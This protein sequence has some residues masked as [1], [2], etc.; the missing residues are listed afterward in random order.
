[1]Y[2]YMCIYIYI[3]M[4]LYLCKIPISSYFSRCFFLCFLR[5]FCTF[6]DRNK[7]EKLRNNPRNMAKFGGIR[8]GGGG[9]ENEM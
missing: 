9:E 7:V 8:G 3:C 4:Y 6:R 1:M 2:M 5:K